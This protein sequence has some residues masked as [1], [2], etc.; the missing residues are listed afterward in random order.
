MK[1]CRKRQVER[2]G[3]ETK[4]RCMHK[5]A[6]T[7]RQHV[8]E[9]VCNACPL[10]VYINKEEKKHPLSLPV[11]ETGNWPSC[12]FRF[13][14]GGSI[15]SCAVTG[16]KATEEICRRCAKDSKMETAR[17]LDKVVNYATAMRRWV[18]AGRPERSDDRVKE[19]FDEFCSKCS[20]YDREKGVCNS[21]GCPSNTD[22]PAIRNK[23]KMATEACPLGQ[24]PSEVEDA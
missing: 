2:R 17:L 5:Q 9:S 19:L 23:L 18:A 1:E 14:A 8:D 22:Q 10:R 13:K 15:P 16:L 7:H 24:F 3:D 21:C 4:H 11:V 20:M 6:G 12:E